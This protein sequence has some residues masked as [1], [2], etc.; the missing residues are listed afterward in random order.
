MLD[1]APTPSAPIDLRGLPL[2]RAAVMA[3]VGLV[4]GYLYHSHVGC[5]LGGCSTDGP[6]P[7]MV[8]GALVAVV[9]A[10]ALP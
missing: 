3:V 7:S 9:V 8:H 6:L 4:G 2:R 5:L 1:P 10:V